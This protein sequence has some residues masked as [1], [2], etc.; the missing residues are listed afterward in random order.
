[1]LKTGSPCCVQRKL[2]HIFPEDA[3]TEARLWG[4]IA[5]M[6]TKR[7]NH[8]RH[9]DQRL[10][11]AER[12]QRRTDFKA[13]LEKKASAADETLIVYVA[14]NAFCWSRIGISTSKRLGNAVCRNGLRRRLREVFR[15]SKGEIP[16]GF[17]LFCIVRSVAKIDQLHRSLLSLTPK[18]VRRLARK[19]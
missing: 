19:S 11:R 16:L 15:R 13:I 3:I 9:C 12:V 5:P 4:I 18:A 10:R 6:E 8:N 7:S 1:M 14:K 17:D 2:V